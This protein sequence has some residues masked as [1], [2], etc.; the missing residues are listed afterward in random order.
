MSEK[1]RFAP[2]IHTAI[3]SGGRLKSVRNSVTSAPTMKTSLPLVRRTPFSPFSAFRRSTASRSS[4]T[5][6]ALN[7]LTESP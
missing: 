4:F 3:S 6:R 2:A 5:V 1:V 7:L